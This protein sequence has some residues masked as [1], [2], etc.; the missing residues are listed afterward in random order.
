MACADG[1]GGF[2]DEGCVVEAFE[3]FE[4][5]EGRGVL[6]DE[7]EVLRF[8]CCLLSDDVSE[9]DS[10]VSFVNISR[11]NVWLL[12][13]ADRGKRFLRVVWSCEGDMEDGVGFHT[14]VG[15]LVRTE[16]PEVRS[17]AVLRS[18]SE[19]GNCPGV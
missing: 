1:F 17:A 19:G 2:E 12:C 18:D 5:E 10:D 11:V 13:R 14:K 15:E 4:L 3:T 16:P 8:D 9:D 6:I 7:G